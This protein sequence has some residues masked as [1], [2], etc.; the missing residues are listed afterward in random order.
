MARVPE[1]CQCDFPE[2]DATADPMPWYARL[3]ADQSPIGFQGGDANLYRY[4]GNEP[5]DATDPSGLEKFMSNSLQQRFDQ[6]PVWFKTLDTGAGDPKEANDGQVNRAE[7]RQRYR[8]VDFDKFNMSHDGVYITVTDM[9]KY[10]AKNGVPEPPPHHD[11]APPEG[12][13]AASDP[14]DA[15]SGITRDQFDRRRNNLAMAVWSVRSRIEKADPLWL[16]GADRGNVYD[17]LDQIKGHLDGLKY[18]SQFRDYDL[19]AAEADLVSVRNRITEAATEYAKTHPPQF[20][21]KIEVKVADDGALT[22]ALQESIGIL[23]F[24]DPTE[25]AVW[26]ANGAVYLFRGKYAAGLLELG[27]GL[28]SGFVAEEKI[29]VKAVGEAGKLAAEGKVAGTAKGS[30]AEVEAI[31]D[32]M[33]VSGKTPR[34][35][36]ELALGAEEIAQLRRQLR[37]IPDSELQI[38]LDSG[39]LAE[40]KANALFSV[41]QNG[42]ARITL[43]E[44]PSWYEFLHEFLHYKQWKADKAAYTALT[45][46]EKELHVFEQ[47]LKPGETPGVSYWARLTKEERLHAIEA[48]RDHWRQFPR[49]FSADEVDKLK[50][51]LQ[52]ATSKVADP[53]R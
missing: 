35:V 50:Q 25:G 43:K 49:E 13:V 11:G 30:L 9:E 21:N 32:R 41:L 36:G 42:T 20:A 10:I 3:L 6:L 18:D 19:H 22:D 44:N 46:G 31:I 33:I 26:T 23:G 14:V 37:A 7:W 28:W 27:G 38:I 12:Q 2:W 47:L 1:P 4:V 5:T 39:K 29:G 24:L 34:G 40:K 45:D 51:L 52:D 53:V 17:V 16:E 15:G 48:I 8:Q